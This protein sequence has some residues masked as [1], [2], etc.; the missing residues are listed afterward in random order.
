MPTQI[1]KVLITG[2]AR[3]IGKAIADE[4]VQR[5]FE[6]IGPQR[7]ELDLAD[8]ASIEAYVTRNADLAV[9]VLIN[10]A[11][12]NVLNDV[13]QIVATDWAAMLQV[14]L[15]APL[16]LMQAFVPGMRARCWGRVLNISSIFSV[17]TKERRAAYSTTKAGLNGL[18]RTAATEFGPDNVLVNAL[19]PGYVETALTHQNNSPADIERICASIPLGRLAKPEE[20]ARYAGF[21]CSEE[22]TYLTGQAIVVDGGF[23][24]K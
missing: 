19:C 5:G 14:N 24:C 2:G 23:T 18:T 9:D 7:A 6:V 20:L 12:I 4:M 15:T 16:R 17:V 10:N 21:L 11:G 13:E 8:V 1:R 22:N 3:G